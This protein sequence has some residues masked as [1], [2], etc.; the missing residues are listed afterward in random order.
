MITSFRQGL[1]DL[2]PIWRQM[3]APATLAGL[4][5]LAACP[6]QEFRLPDDLWA[7]LVY[8]VAVAYHR[9]VMPREHLL[10]ALTPLYLGRTASF[11]LETGG[12][13][14]AEAEGRIE[15]LCRA[16]EDSKS[17][18]LARWPIPE[19]GQEGGAHA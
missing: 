14:S 8:D 12:L 17:Y 13:T 3:L 7:R 11:V 4:L 5:P 9:R 2:E 6:L 1:R 15:M 16:Y 18:L 19:N 10:R